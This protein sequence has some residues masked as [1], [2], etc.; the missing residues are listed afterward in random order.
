MHKRL[1]YSALLSE[2]QLNAIKEEWR[3]YAIHCYENDIDEHHTLGEYVERKLKCSLFRTSLKVGYL[4]SD[5]SETLLI[6]LLKYS[7]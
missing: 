7:A 5:C 2:A 6:A 4:E 3:L 1:K